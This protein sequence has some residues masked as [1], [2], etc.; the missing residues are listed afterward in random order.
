[1]QGEAVSAQGNAYAENVNSYRS[2]RKV[3]MVARGSDCFNFELYRSKNSLP[4]EDGTSLW[5]HFVEHG[6]F[7]GRT[8]E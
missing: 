6:Q 5:K 7:E 1:M 3:M 2:A 8:F 4:F